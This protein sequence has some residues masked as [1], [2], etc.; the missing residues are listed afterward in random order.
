MQAVTMFMGESICMLLF[1]IAKKKPEYKA[2][3]I[4][5]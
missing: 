4:E 2:E 3:A 5:A 1:L